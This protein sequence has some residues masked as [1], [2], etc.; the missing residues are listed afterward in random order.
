MARTKDATAMPM[1]RAFVFPTAAER[2]CHGATGAAE[3][4]PASRMS[5]ERCT[6]G[7]ASAGADAFEESAT[8]AGCFDDRAF[9]HDGKRPRITLLSPTC[10]KASNGSFASA[11]RRCAIPTWIGGCASTWKREEIHLATLSRRHSSPRVL[12]ASKTAST[13]HRSSSFVTVALRNLSDA[14]QTQWQSRLDQRRS[15]QSIRFR[16]HP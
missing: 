13:A 11:W 3:S 9:I 4:A 6:K 7:C 12:C 10:R 16:T 8:L 5:S 14:T 15:T 1:A 2:D